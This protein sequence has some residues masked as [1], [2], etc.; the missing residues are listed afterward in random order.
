MLASSRIILVGE[1]PHAHEQEAIDFAVKELP[2]TDPY[3]AW[4]LV[5]LLEPAT[6]RL[7]EID[8]LVLGYSA[9]YLVEIKSGPGKYEG[10][11]VDWYRTAPDQPTRWM[12]PPLRLANLKAKV[13]KS[14]LRSKMRNPDRAPR[15]EALV[16][17]SHADIDLRLSTE[18]RAGVVTRRDL[19][20]AI[21]RHEFPGAP[22]DWRAQ[23]IDQPLQKDVTQALESLGLRKRKGKLF[24]GAYELGPL[25]DDG[26]MQLDGGGEG[27]SA[28]SGY[29]D[30]QAQHR[31]TPALSRRA[32]VYLIPQQTTVERRQVLRRAAE[33]EVQLLH[34]VREHA[35]VLTLLDYIPDA[36]LGPTLLFDTFDGASPLDAFLR[37]NPDLPFQDRVDI[38]EQV[39]RAL[40][41][42]HKKEVRHGA[43]GPHAILVRRSSEDDRIQTRLF[44]FQLGAGQHVRGTVHASALS[45]D[46]WELYQAPE[47]REEVGR[48]TPSSDLFS[49]GAIAY[50][51][52]AGSAPAKNVI[53]LDERL[54]REGQLDP[55][56]ARDDIPAPIAEAITFA[57]QRL[58]ANRVDEANEWIELLIDGLTRP[59]PE[60]AIAEI[61]PLEARAKDVLNGDLTV[62][63]VLGYGAT[64]RVLQVERGSDGRVYALKVSL[65]IEHDERLIEER[66][67][68]DQLEHPRIVRCVAPLT[69]ANRTCLLLTHAGEQ[70]LQ[71]LLAR[72]GTV[73]LDYASRFGEDLLS[74]LEQL[75]E[76]KIIHRDI[77]PANVGV[78]TPGKGATHLTLFDFSLGMA[79]LSELGVGTA[80]YRDPFLRARGAWD[81]AADRWGAA[82]TL[83]EMLTGARP[84]IEALG[85]GPAASK[86]TLAAERF[87][88]AV[89]D[90]LIAFFDKALAP[91][92]ELRFASARE[93]HRA[94]IAAFDVPVEAPPPSVRTTAASAPEPERDSIAPSADGLTQDQ[95]AAI[96]PMTPAEALP[97][98][99]RAKN[100]LD[101]AG[102][103]HAK[104]LL[105]LPDNR[106]SSIRGVGLR[107]AK[108]VLSFRDRWKGAVALAPLVSTPFF[109]GAYAG[110]DVM[111]ETT[112][113]DREVVL[114]L[115]DAGVHT[116]GAL[117]AAPTSHI[118]TIAKRRGF[119]AK[120]LSDLLEREARNAGDRAKPPTLE[121]WLDALLPKAKK[122]TAYFLSLY[123]LV[124]P[125]LDRIDVTVR[126]VAEHHARSTAAIYLAL[127]EARDG[128]SKHGA[129][130]ELRDL[131]HALV[132]EAGGALPL[133]HAS[134]ALRVRM[135]FDKA[136]PSGMLLAR[137]AA[138]F[139]IVA[140]VERELPE[141]LRIL[142]M[143]AGAP[144][145]LATEAYVEVVGALGRA[146]DELASRSVLA[147]PGEAARQFAEIARDTPLAAI[148]PERLADMAAQASQSAAR[149]ARLEIYPRGLPPER[150][151]ELSAAVLASGLGPEEIQKRVAGRYPEAAPLPDRPAL[152]TLLEPHGLIWAEREAQYRRVGEA[153]TTTFE[154]TYRAPPRLPTASSGQDRA[155]SPEAIDARA[156]DEKIAYAVE[157]RLLRIVGVR[158]DSARDAALA[159][160]RRTGTRPV[161]FD[162]ELIA[163]MRTAMKTNEVD[164]EV[165][166]RADAE[167]PAGAAWPNLLALAEAAAADVASKLL[168]PKN[169]LI[170]VQPGLL[171]RYRLEGFLQALIDA[172][173][174]RDSAAIFL[175]VPAHDTGG[176]PLINRELPIRGV[177]PSDGLWVSAHWLAN[178]HNAAA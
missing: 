175:L 86:L 35:N 40:A 97:L 159:L 45:S 174:D 13:L 66:R 127:G 30:R 71:R 1:T 170:L 108:E 33:R 75:E 44:N 16:F 142:R 47:L 124:E 9:L 23:R 24:A 129:M 168:P 157:R 164:P 136:A 116:L 144:W 148:S 88:P 140:E 118:T 84:S 96:S 161:S 106:L 18:G 12:D 126:E 109:P 34:S 100:A 95:L 39:A 176:L 41:H 94:W 15:V 48:P 128:W 32:R 162:A 7:Y 112:K 111:L 133:E 158:A 123:G 46:P 139:R 57:T 10:D 20:R 146:A 115:V 153:Q 101:R 36:P 125:F 152:D 178:K 72:E 107:V 77:K 73:S 74:A 56:A 87:D 60:V 173:K 52:F 110:D 2:G 165:V 67:I 98:S 3:T 49:L 172:S 121:A 8:L 70:T 169:P 38:V 21:T 102:V 83:H 61:D 99:V 145:A 80:V 19:V 137:G 65:A 17:L 79:P 119:D 6:G 14:R 91:D 141:G 11:N 167:G 163:A 117:A 28:P 4:G 53:D 22:S 54:Q 166:H 105:E 113:L 114:A 122:R 59:E 155:M 29:Q 64:S 130:R 134:A 138:L 92:V 154:T 62:Q 171:A 69:I 51:V 90:R 42:C 132:E 25:I 5:E 93:M 151:L 104:D 26:I 160:A 85:E 143:G 150:A 177:L 76:K 50:L 156:F 58:V 82:V 78:G 131:A 31:E 81:P 43:L 89:R 68:L 120:L 135:P 27:P 37:K 149:S 103:L 147:S 55:R 63:Q